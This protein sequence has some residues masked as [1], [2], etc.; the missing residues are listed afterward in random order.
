MRTEFIAQP[1]DVET[2]LDMPGKP[3]A[4]FTWM[5]QR[6]S[7]ESVAATWVDT[8]W[9]PLRKRPKRWWQRRH[10]TYYQVEADDGCLYEIYLDRGNG[11]WVLYRRFLVEGLSPDERAAQPGKAA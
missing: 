7:V 3:P 11:E 4:A 8:G 9:G 5:G 1:I 6:K 10:R 2:R